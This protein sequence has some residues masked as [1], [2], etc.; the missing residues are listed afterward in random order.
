MRTNAGA[1]F[2]ARVMSDTAS[3]GTGSYAPATYLAVTEDATAP[4]ATDTTLTGELAAGGLA[5]AVGVYAHTAGASSYTLTKT[6]TSSDATTRTIRK[7]GI[8]NAAAAG[9]M[10]FETLVP[11]PPVLVSGD[12]LTITATINL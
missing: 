3:T 8:F 7:Y 5:R 11:N 10:V 6:W 2:Q 12:T 4:V 9:T 1:D